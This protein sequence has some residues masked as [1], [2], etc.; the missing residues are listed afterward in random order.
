MSLCHATAKSKKEEY[1]IFKTKKLAYRP[2]IIGFASVE[3]GTGTTTISLAL[4]N[5]LCNKLGKRVAY[6][7]LNTTNQILS[8]SPKKDTSY[9]SYIGI[10]M[11]PCTQ[12]TSLSEILQKD[13]DYFVLDMG[14]I[15]T[16]TACEFS[17]CDKQFIVGSLCPW[18]RKRTFEK[19]EHL[20]NTT[21]IHRESITVLGDIGKKESTFSFFS[22]KRLRIYSF[23][24]IKNPFQ[25]EPKIFDAFYEIL[26]GK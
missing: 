23:P 17:K 10:T 2:K 9:F 7:E 24:Y 5:F 15:N 18:K 21:Y 16:Y 1:L 22:H 25:L 12:V 4:S 19:I 14:I 13:Y 26:D 8:L 20:F 11:F 6:L 3:H